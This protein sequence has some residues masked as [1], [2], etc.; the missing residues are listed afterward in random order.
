VSAVLEL[1]HLVKDY[2]GL[3]PLRIDRFV[4]APRDR[5]AMLGLDRPAAETLINLITGA[6][7]PDSGD[8][9]IFGRRTADITDSSDWLAVVDRLGIVT[10]RAVLLEALSS[11]Q[12]LALPYSLDVEPPSDDLRSKAA[13]LAREVGLPHADWDRAAGSLDS[14]GRARL[15]LGRALALGPEVLLLEHATAGVARSSVAA[16]AA[17]IRRAAAGRGI[18]TL[19]F[20]ADPDFA[21]AVAD[22]VLMLDAA[23]G[24]LTRRRRGWFM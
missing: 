10:E 22:R 7:L 15:R 8:V 13:A 18:A 12:N 19:S 11:I 17:D 21:A 6:A 23:S 9:R 4:L 14:L 16:L 20:G 5:S 1:S 2:R 3:R 24:R